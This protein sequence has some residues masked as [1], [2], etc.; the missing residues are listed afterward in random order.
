M[1]TVFLLVIVAAA[2]LG[3]LA[4][5]FRE[6]IFPSQVDEKKLAVKPAEITRPLAEFLPERFEADE[7]EAEDIGWLLER[8]RAALN[9]TKTS[10]N[11]REN[12]ARQDEMLEQVDELSDRVAALQLRMND[13]K[14]ALLEREGLILALEQL[15]NDHLDQQYMLEGLRAEYE[16][17]RIEATELRTE[18]IETYQEKEAL[19][20]QVNLLRDLNEDS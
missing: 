18:A 19:R 14:N 17:L 9:A 2:G 10:E 20:T 3:L 8:K 1:F 13:W 16:A 11:N 12:N 15:R 6:K 5:Q 4:W 7:L